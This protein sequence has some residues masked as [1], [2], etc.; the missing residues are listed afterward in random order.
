MLYLV[1]RFGLAA[2]SSDLLGGGCK[3][4]QGI[5][6]G[7]WK[8]D[9][10]GCAPEKHSVQTTANEDHWSTC[11]CTQTDSPRVGEAVADGR[12]SIFSRE[13]PLHQRL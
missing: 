2:L 7:G 9:G 5:K 6:T 3:D 12:V 11:M 13:V 1:E 4:Y 10:S 8:F